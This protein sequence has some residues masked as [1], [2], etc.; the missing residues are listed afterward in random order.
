[1]E[2]IQRP[3]FPTNFKFPDV[4]LE[5]I[6]SFIR[7]DVNLTFNNTLNS[8][9]VIAS[10]SCESSRR[11]SL[12]DKVYPLLKVYRT[13]ELFY[14]PIGNVKN[15]DI[16]IAYV[17]AYSP[18]EKGTSITTYVASDICRV[19]QNSS[20]LDDIPFTVNIEKPITVTYDNASD[21]DIVYDYAKITCTIL[22]Q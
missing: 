1:M 6:A 22:T 2:I 9:K 3:T 20:I 8:N 7:D 12:G 21:S 15:L 5:T 18:K 19:L 4:D 14:F 11:L 16:T 13:Q 10:F 17:L